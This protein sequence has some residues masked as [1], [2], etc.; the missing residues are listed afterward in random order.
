MS[1]TSVEPDFHD[2]TLTLVADFTAPADDVWELWAN[3]RK[4][5]RW[6]GPPGYP[7]TF[8]VD[9]ITEGAEVVYFMTSP[10]GNKHYGWWRIESVNP[11]RSIEI[12]DEPIQSGSFGGT[13][14]G[15]G[16]HPEWH[17]A[18]LE[19]AQLRFGRVSQDERAS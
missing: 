4:L 9:E 18:E 2:L 17:A 7:A 19:A 14:V 16:D 10:E 1:V 3:P 12:T 8:E 13:H 11:P 15:G 5:E 6:W